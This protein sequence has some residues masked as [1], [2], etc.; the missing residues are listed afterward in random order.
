MSQWNNL[1]C[2]FCFLTLQ[3]LILDW[4][5][6]QLE[7]YTCILFYKKTVLHPTLYCEDFL[8]AE[9]SRLFLRFSQ[10]MSFDL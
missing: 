6:Y 3:Q 7:S 10:K 8:Q 4:N 2:G 5:E 9:C 1:T